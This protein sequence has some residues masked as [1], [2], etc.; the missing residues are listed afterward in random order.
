M[1]IQNLL[2]QN[3]LRAKHEVSAKDKSSEEFNDLLGTLLAQTHE[4]KKNASLPSF[5]VNA[6]QIFGSFDNNSYRDQP[7]A[8]SEQLAS[9]K[10]R[11]NA[12]TSDKQN[13]SELAPLQDHDKFSRQLNH[14]EHKIG[15][16][17]SQEDK[18]LLN[19]RHD[20][21]S[22]SSFDHFTKSLN[23]SALDGN[24][25]ENPEKNPEKNLEENIEENFAATNKQTLPEDESQK[26]LNNKNNH[27]PLASKFDENGSATKQPQERQPQEIIEKLRAT[28]SARPQFKK[29][30]ATNPQAQEIQNL[31]QTSPEHD[32]GTKSNLLNKNNAQNNSL[33]LSPEKTADNSLI[34][35]Q[36]I[37]K[38]PNSQASNPVSKGEDIL[39]G[40]NRLLIES[41]SNSSQKK[42][43]Q[44][45]LLSGESAQALQE[46]QENSVAGYA[47]QGSLS[48]GAK[49][50]LMNLGEKFAQ[51]STPLTFTEPKAEGITIINGNG[52]KASGNPKES[53]NIL[54][55]NLKFTERADFIKQLQNLIRHSVQNDY[56]VIRINLDPQNLGEIN[57]KLIIDQENA[58]AEIITYNPSTLEL[59]KAEAKE[60]VAAL[61]QAGLNSSFDELS[62]MNYENQSSQHREEKQESN[63]Q[64]PKEQT[65]YESQNIKSHTQN[66]RNYREREDIRSINII[67]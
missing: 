39:K 60:I 2:V 25:K 10:T 11:S 32:D 12:S 18:R 14:K 37:N 51:N 19:R 26:L 24:L 40:Q 64:I 63:E 16:K 3:L 22:G 45:G 52:P 9:T 30:I 57:I 66:Y 46:I 44:F 17:V 1:S 8:A 41:I 34:L 20:H 61:E 53:N 27:G 43:L 7:K 65:N 4:E 15:N 29:I 31:S 42:E 13:S 6:M 47:L 58:K 35:N 23:H 21:M 56:D 38:A 59:I 67:A 54:V 49:Q 33:T 5:G 48:S 50:S 36:F 55:Q 28:T 62:F